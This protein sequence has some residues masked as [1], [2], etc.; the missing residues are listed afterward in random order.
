MTERRFV[1]DTNVL[2]SRLLMPQ[3]T[4]ARALDHALARGVL[5][6]STATLAELA[7]VLSRPK[8]DPYVSRHDREEFIRKLGGVARLVD[9]R[10]QDK[11][12]RDPKDD[13]FLHV[14]VNGE[15]CAIVTGDADLLALHPF[16]GV[17][18]V[19]PGDFL[20]RQED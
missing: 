5:L 16:H 18:I 17:A 4:P 19:T 6:V 12:C 7:D 11:A 2:V 15:A 1:V 8:F 20:N 13:K 10:W 14:A 9:I 3:S